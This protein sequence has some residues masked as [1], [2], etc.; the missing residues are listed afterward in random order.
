ML[1][2][3]NIRRNEIPALHRKVVIVH[4]AVIPRVVGWVDI[5][6]LHLAEVGLLQQFQH[7]EIV[8][9]DVEVLAVERALC[10]IPPD[11][12]RHDGTQ[13]RIDRRI[14][15][16]DRLPLVRPCERI[17][18]LTP[19]HDLARQLLP[20]HIEVD[21]LHGLPVAHDLRQSVREQPPHRLHI[22]RHIIHAVH[23]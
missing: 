9:L 12:V 19:L 22:P 11:T 4:E 10:A 6:H 21:R 18:L 1:I 13:R 5:D 2:I 3:G 20:Q 23:F 17:A 15:R 7:I 16:K 8:P 14:R